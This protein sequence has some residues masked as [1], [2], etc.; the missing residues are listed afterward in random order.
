[1]T[2][3]WVCIDC[4]AR[5]AESGPCRACGK[6][7]TLDARLEQTRELMYD[8]D[9]RIAQKAEG[10]A[11]MIGVVV[12]CGLIFGLWLVPSYWGL[13]GTI[14]PGLPFFADQWGAMAVIGFLVSKVLEKR[15][16]KKRFPYLDSTQQ[17]IA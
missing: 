7:D 1:M 17:I 16:A 13:R 8:V 9:L 4:G 2:N 14:Y 11:R 5:Q 6:G 15:L 10:R 3:P 12:G